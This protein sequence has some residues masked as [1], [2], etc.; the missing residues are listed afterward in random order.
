M[1]NDR[2][3]ADVEAYF[4]PRLRAGWIMKVSGDRA[5]VWFEG[6]NVTITVGHEFEFV[7][8]GCDASSVIRDFGMVLRRNG[9]IR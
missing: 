5:R 3:L 6:L 9:V 7:C 4:V 2:D 1:M 8:D